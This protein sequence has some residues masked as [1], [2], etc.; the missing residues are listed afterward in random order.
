MESG[1]ISLAPLYLFVRK[2]TEAQA[3]N[4][5]SEIGRTYA[6]SATDVARS[7]AGR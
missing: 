3:L 6:G 1:I 7:I 4:E 2:H 5:R